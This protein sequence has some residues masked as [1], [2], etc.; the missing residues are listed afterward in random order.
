MSQLREPAFHRR[1]CDGP[2]RGRL[3][4]FLRHAGWFAGWNFVTAPFLRISNA[5]AWLLSWHTPV[6]R[7]AV[8]GVFILARKGLEVRGNLFFGVLAIRS[9]RAF[10][11]GDT[12]AAN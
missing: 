1:G 2:A 12:K 7:V 11:L 8:A 4:L 3:Q 5:R 9:G 10:R 6:V